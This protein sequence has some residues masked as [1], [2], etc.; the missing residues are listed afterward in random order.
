MVKYVWRIARNECKIQALWRK[1]HVL[2]LSSKDPSQANIARTLQVNESTI[3][4][5]FHH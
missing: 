5:D 1:N 3:S 4:R 2:D